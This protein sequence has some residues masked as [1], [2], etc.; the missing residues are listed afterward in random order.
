MKL[1]HPLKIRIRNGTFELGYGTVAKSTS[2]VT[3]GKSTR[4]LRQSIQPKE[5]SQRLQAGLATVNRYGYT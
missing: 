3:K 5:I 2:A 1:E 4:A